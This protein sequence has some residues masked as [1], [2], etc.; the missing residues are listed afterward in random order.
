MPRDANG[1]A[2]IIGYNTVCDFNFN[3]I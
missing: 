1:Q 2:K 3:N